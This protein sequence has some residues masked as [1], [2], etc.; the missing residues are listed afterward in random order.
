MAVTASSLAL[1]YI[2]SNALVLITQRLLCSRHPVSCCAWI[3]FHHC[4]KG[5][6]YEV[7][8]TVLPLLCLHH[9]WGTGY[10]CHSYTSG[11]LQYLPEP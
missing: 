8:S 11:K 2:N 3:D 6:S 4:I 7:R 1:A 9:S 5:L 10:N